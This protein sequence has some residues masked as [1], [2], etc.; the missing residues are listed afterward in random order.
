MGADV[1]VL[2]AVQL[3]KNGNPVQSAEYK[4]SGVILDL[5]PQI[6]GQEIEQQINQQLSSF[7][8]TTTGVNNSP[9]LTKREILTNVGASDGDVIVLGGLDEKRSSKDSSGLPF[10]RGDL[11]ERHR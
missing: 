2:G 1:P 10:L 3:D 4:P 7:I 9:T 6:R 11:G 5:T 8:A